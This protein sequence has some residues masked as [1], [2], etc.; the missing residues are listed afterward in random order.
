ML[1]SEEIDYTLPQMVEHNLTLTRK[2]LVKW[3]EACKDFPLLDVQQ[4]DDWEEY[5]RETDK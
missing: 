3:P 5:S 2:M 1:S 4:I